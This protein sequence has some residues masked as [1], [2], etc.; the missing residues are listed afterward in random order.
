MFRRPVR[1]AVRLMTKNAMT[2][3]EFFR[4]NQL[5]QLGQFENAALEFI[6]LAHRMERTGKPRQAA[7]LHAQAALA[8]AKAG[9]EP[10][11]TNQANIA[12]SQ[13][14]LLGMKQ[15]IIEFKTQLDQELHPESIPKNDAAWVEPCE[16]TRP[17]TAFP[18]I[19]NQHGKLPAICS[20]CGAPVRSDEVEWIDDTSAECD[21]CGVVL[22]VE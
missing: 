21:F 1:R 17:V 19:I 16:T 18:P 11:A 4:A 9:I 14:T 2:Q 10:R 3:N 7:N 6:Q 12:F 5:F 15:R 20:Q 8:W 22:Q 13:F